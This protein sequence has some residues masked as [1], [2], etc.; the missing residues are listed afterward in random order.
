M[1]TK[2]ILPLTLLSLLLTA[3]VVTADPA[4]E[5]KIKEV[6]NLANEYFDSLRKDAAEGKAEA[7]FVLSELYDMGIGGVEKNYRK[8]AL[9]LVKAATQRHSKAQARIAN[10]LYYGYHDL[11]EHNFEVALYHARCAAAQGEGEAAG[12]LGIIYL[13]GEDLPKNIERA[14]MFLK[15]AAI[16][17]FASAQYN[18]G[19]LYYI[20]YGEERWND[21]HKWFV[22]ASTQNLNAAQSA[23]AALYAHPSFEKYDP[24]KA[25][26]WLLVS[27]PNTPE[28]QI[29]AVSKLWSALAFGLS[30]EEIEQGKSLA[31]N[32]EQIILNEAQQ[33]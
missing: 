15:L 24:V 21:A 1:N 4:F 23:L 30:E 26:A 9:W 16:Q 29:K 7:Q 28:E 19:K 3:L 31:E 5:Q 12:L 20:E 13:K 18:L 6:S 8:S 14:E 25:Y 22:A 2:N 27:L 17:D 11:I 10:Y 32:L 33:D